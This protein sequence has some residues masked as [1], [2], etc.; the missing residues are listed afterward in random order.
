M[1][2][3]LGKYLVPAKA[4][5]SKP[6]SIP[7]EPMGRSMS[8]SQAARGATSGY[9]KAFRAGGGEAAIPMQKTTPFTAKME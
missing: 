6:F 3:N 2:N 1:A 8:G 7:K 5:S 4:V 9:A